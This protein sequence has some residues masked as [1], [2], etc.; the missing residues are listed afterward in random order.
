[1][2]KSRKKL[3]ISITAVCCSIVVLVLVFGLLFRLKTVSVEFRTRADISCSQLEE[4]ILDNV[5]KS[6]E[7]KIG[8]NLLFYNFDDNIAKIEKAH[9]YIKVE[10]IVRRFPNEISVLV[11]ER[12][13]AYRVQ[14]KTG[15]E[16][17]VLDE[18]FKVLCKIASVSDSYGNRTFEEV[19]V[20]LAGY[21]ISAYNGD[22]VTL[23]NGEF[24]K[25]VGSG[26]LSA[27]NFEDIGK[28]KSISI[29]NSDNGLKFEIIMKTS[30]TDTGDGCKIIVEGVTDLKLKV[31]SGVSLFATTL[32]ETPTADIS[33]SKI[34]ISKDSTGNYKATFTE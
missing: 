29:T 22:F 27:Y 8:K 34:V 32:Q 5:K 2:Q 4:G 9:P 12:I 13:P 15:G 25:E 16:W 26:I 7:F 30:A 33:N 21:S 6:G 18:D 24:I 23:E 19:T 17:F 31:Y 1:M 10:Q 3:W 28:A 11:S 14:S 20:E